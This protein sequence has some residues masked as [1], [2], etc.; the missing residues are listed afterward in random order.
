MVITL[1]RASTIAFLFVLACSS[2][3]ITIPTEDVS[4]LAAAVTGEAARSI[5][6]DG[7]FMLGLPPAE[8][9]PLMDEAQARAVAE[10]AAT[11]FTPFIA[12]VLEGQHRQPID[13]TRLR[14]CGP[15]YF[16][17]SAFQ[18]IPDGHV[19]QL[20]YHLGSRWI[21]AVCSDGGRPAISVSVA[22]NAV[23]FREVDGQW[24]IP[25]NAVV[26]V[27]I[28][29]EW[30]GALPIS[31]EGA[32]L[33]A[34]KLSGGRVTS[35]PVLYAPNPIEEMPQGARWSFDLDR[36]VRVRGDS[37]GILRQLNRLTIGSVPIHRNSMLRGPSTL[38]VTKPDERR[39][40]H[41]S[42]PTQSGTNVPLTLNVQ[43]GISI[44]L[45]RATIL[46]QGFQ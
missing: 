30:A 24:V 25:H 10:H 5:G 6:V 3:R 19:E 40:L 8:T 20:V 31:P 37:S 38:F 43:A 17:R 9:R 2:Q 22:A 36:E 13:F 16:A 33:L 23:S 42:M 4:G 28:P 18:P 21:L 7:R 44:D 41:F 46:P 11:V 14:T 35:V 39:T 27:G 26:F 32:V 45:E 34:A 1:W 12:A 15:A 29:P